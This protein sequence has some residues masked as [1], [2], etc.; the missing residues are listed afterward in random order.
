MKKEVKFEEVQGKKT[1]RT[2]NFVLESTEAN[3]K[4]IDAYVGVEF[5][6]VYKITVKCKDKAGKTQTQEALFYC[7]CPGSGIQAGVG[8]KFVPK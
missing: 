1:E 2:F 3:E 8:K 5:S 6:I 4:L 7:A